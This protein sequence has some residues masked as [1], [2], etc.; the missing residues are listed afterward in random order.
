[1]DF[2]YACLVFVWRHCAACTGEPPRGHRRPTAARG[3]RAA[4]P[5]DSAVLH[6]DGIKAACA[7]QVF[8]ESVAC[9]T[10]VF[11]REELDIARGNCTNG[12]G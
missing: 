5:L 3:L 4:P 6:A 11:D 1:M 9:L 2:H 12:D 8:E 7:A 10:K